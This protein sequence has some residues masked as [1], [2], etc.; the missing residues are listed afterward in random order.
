MNT[1]PT[2]AAASLTSSIMETSSAGEITVNPGS[3]QAR[4]RSSMLICDGPSS[5]IEMPLCVPTTFRFTLGYAAVTRSC[6]NPLF[7][8]NTEKLAANGIFPADARPAPIAIMLASAMPHSKKRCGKFLRESGRVGGFGKIRVQRDHIRIRPSEF[9]QRLAE[10]F[11]RG[12]AQR[13]VVFRFGGH[14]ASSWSAL[15]HSSRVGAVP[16]NL[17]LFSMNDTPL[18]L[19]V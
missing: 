9:H 2:C 7:R 17:G 16:W 19:T 4:L 13:Q 3:E 12:R 6:S 5:P 18:P 10:S 1:G 15:A 8:A 11:A 14:Q